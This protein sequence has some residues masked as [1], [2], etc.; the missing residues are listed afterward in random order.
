VCLSQL[1]AIE[2]EAESSGLGGHFD[3]DQTPCRSA[4]LGAR[5]AELHEQFFALEVLHRRDV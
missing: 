4:S 2:R 5:R 3:I 1:V